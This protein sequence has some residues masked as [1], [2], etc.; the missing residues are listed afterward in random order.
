M[1]NIFQ[2]SQGKEMSSEGKRELLRDIYDACC[3]NMVFYTEAGNS[4]ASVL[5]GEGEYIITT[6]SFSQVA[7]Q[8]VI[9]ALISKYQW[10]TRNN[11]VK[12]LKHMNKNIKE[13]MRQI[14]EPEDALLGGKLV[15]TNKTLTKYYTDL[16]KGEA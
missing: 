11:T 15:F 8:V 7:E 4:M 5:E 9:P 12:I 10:L 13:W 6:M 14:P 3:N 16:A 1:P 2:R